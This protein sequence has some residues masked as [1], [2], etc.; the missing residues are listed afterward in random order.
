M[1]FG[2]STLRRKLTALV[3]LP[4]G[5]T[6]VC[7]G[8]LE[9]VVE[10][11]V[12]EDAEHRV[13]QAEKA[14]QGR[15]DQE[16][17]ALKL[18]LSAL[19]DSDHVLQG[20]ARSEA[21]YVSEGL[22]DFRE[23]YPEVAVLVADR[24]GRVLA[25]AG[26]EGISELRQLPGLEL[27]AAPR[28]VAK[29]LSK[30]GCSGAT[31]APARLLAMRAGER[32]IVVACQP[33]DEAFLQ[34]AAEQLGMGLAL[35]DEDAGHAILSQTSGFPSDAPPPRGET[36]LHEEAGELWAVAHFCPALFPSERGDCT[37]DALSA[38]PVGGL[39]RTIRGD[40]AWLLLF[41]AGAGLGALLLGGRM[42]LRMTRALE[43]LVGGFRKL[44]VQ[45]YTPVPVMATGDELEELAR[46]FNQAVAGLEERDRLKTTFG[47]YM[48]E[49]V[50]SHLLTNR[51][52]LGGDT[53]QVTILF[54]DIRGFT[55]ISE[56]LDAQHL[57][58]L[59]NEYF[60]EMVD[61]VMDHGGVV[62]KYI[63][64]AIMVVFGAPVPEP[65]DALRAV[66]AAVKMREALARLNRR[67]EARG[68]TP[69]RTGVGLHSGEVVAGNIGSE[70]R[71][72]YT[73][74]GDA[75]NLASRLEGA[76]KDLGADLVIS[77]TT[78]ELVREHVTARV[79]GTITVKGREQPVA[80]YA[81]DAVDEAAVQ[82]V[83]VA[84]V[85]VDA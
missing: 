63:G 65:D 1:A 45:Q 55:S 52:Q 2:L 25:A 68:A 15:L 70:R 77:E 33:L 18:E 4:V 23:S 48:T 47:K 59:L 7:L 38:L 21:S 20:L 5:V 50:M 32:G 49:S 36:A 16:L 54:S 14:L 85:L 28:V 56:Q 58:A 6:A 31:R 83:P 64:D 62:D 27:P 19:A 57:V 3:L 51:V 26:L 12:L 79:L 74:I 60:T 84:S 67:L 73:V 72:E 43:A 44:A 46:G 82:A 8:A 61:I 9:Q 11:Q 66:R 17:K 22:S 24:A 69:I 78:Y 29:V 13:A 41:L 53:L 42:A 81:V 80:V 40:F 39:R 30:R 71:M 75:V 10:R 76:T 37:L 35:V 34:E